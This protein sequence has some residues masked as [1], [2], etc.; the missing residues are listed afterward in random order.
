MTTGQRKY[1]PPPDWTDPKPAAGCEVNC[2]TKCIEVIFLIF[3]LL[4]IRY[5]VE[6]CQILCLKMN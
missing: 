2:D 3:N 5:F 4:L 1:G 6:N